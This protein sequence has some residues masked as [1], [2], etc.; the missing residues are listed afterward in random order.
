M[1]N[2]FLGLSLF[3]MLLSFFII[4]NAVSDFEDTKSRPVLNSL[5][6]AF[7]NKDPIDLAAPGQAPTQSQTQQLGSTLD[8]IE[9]LF[10]SQIASAETKQNRL[11]TT[12]YMRLPFKDFQRSMFSSL[13]TPDPRQALRPKAFQQKDINMLPLLVSLMETQLD[14]KYKMDM[15]LNVDASPSSLSADDS[16]RF[17]A[18]NTSVS[19]IAEKLE[20][21]GLPRSQVAVGLKEGEA[22]IIELIFRRHQPFNP[23]GPVGAQDSAQA[24]ET[25]ETG[26]P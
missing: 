2:Q 20:E 1:A 9:A 6:V 23:L 8:K 19:A 7:S 22:D 18:L 3:V 11:G 12:M 13:R 25:E 5:T 15:I 26:A 4:L 24:A 21:A 14:V 17:A 10:Q 16:A